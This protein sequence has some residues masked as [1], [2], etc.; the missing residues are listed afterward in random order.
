MG[1]FWDKTQFRLCNP[2]ERTNQP[3]NKWMKNITPL[4][5]VGFLGG[6]FKIKM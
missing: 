6:L 5:G 1:L 3:T 4:A 2:V